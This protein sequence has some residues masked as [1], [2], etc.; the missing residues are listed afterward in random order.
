MKVIKLAAF[1]CLSFSITAFAQTPKAIEADLLRLLKK[2]DSNSPEIDKANDDFAKKL[3][4]YTEKYPAT[5]DQSFESL[6]KAHLDISTSTDGLFRIYSWDTWTGGTMH[7]FESLFQYKSGNGTISTIDM[8]KTEGDSRPNYYKM[9]TF[10]AN[11]QK[12]YLAIWLNIGSTKL[13][14]NGVKVFS[15]INGKLRDDIKLIKTVTG[16]HNQLYYEYDNGWY[17]KFDINFDAATKTIQLPLITGDS[18][19]TSKFITYKFTGKYFE[20]VKN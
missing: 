10:T 4:Y 6:K 16:M 2:I 12:Y 9:Y 18:K 13:G 19:P 14:M 1:I 7:Y 15:I 17:E 11:T 20:K 8:P 5:L 3:K